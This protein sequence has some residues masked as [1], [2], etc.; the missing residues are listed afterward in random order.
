METYNNTKLLLK[1]EDA[2][3]SV[4]YYDSFFVKQET[5]IKKEMLNTSETI[6]ILMPENYFEIIDIN[7]SELTNDDLWLKIKYGEISGYI[8]FS[9]LGE[10]WTLIENN[11]SSTR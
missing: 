8:P 4:K 5:K 6:L 7:C 3:S 11:L 10:N 9:S 1:A 2:Y